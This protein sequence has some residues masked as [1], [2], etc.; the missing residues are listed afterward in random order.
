MSDEIIEKIAKDVAELN[1]HFKLT[2]RL[3]FLVWSAY[4]FILL[5]VLMISHIEHQS[6]TDLENETLEAIQTVG[7][8]VG[9]DIND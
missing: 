2:K 9:G 6:M 5:I 8:I 1:A 4:A 7:T 3:K